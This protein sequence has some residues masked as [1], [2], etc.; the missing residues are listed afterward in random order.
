MRILI[1]LSIITFSIVFNAKAQSAL[2]L[3]ISLNCEKQ[4]LSSVLSQIETHTALK[5]S[6]NSH[7]LATDSLVTIK[8]AG[9]S[10]VEAL[11]QLLGEHFEFRQAGNFI[12]IRYAP[13]VL[14]ML[15]LETVGDRDRYTIKGQIIERLTSLP[16]ANASIFEK[17]LLVSTLSDQQGYFT[18][19]LKNS[20]QPLTLTVTKDNFKSIEMHFL[21]EVMITTGNRNSPD[22]FF[23]GDSGI[24][25]ETWLG[26]MLVTTRQKIQSLNIGGLL[27]EAPYQ[28][29]IVPGLNSHGSL[30]GQ[31]INKLS[32]N[33]IGAYSAGVDG[34]EVGLVFNI[35]K[36]DVKSFQ[37]AGVF[38]LV[39]GDVQ[40][41]QIAGLAN[42]V[43]GKVRGAQFSLGYNHV[44]KAFKGTQVGAI[45]NSVNENF[46]GVQASIGLNSVGKNLEGI[47]AAVFGNL[48]NG[49]ARGV[50]IAGLA[51]LNRA[52]DGLNVATLLNLTSQSL[53]GAQVGILNYAKTMRGV[54]VGLMNISGKNDGYSIG[55]INIAFHGYHKFGFS[56]NETTPYNLTYRGGSRRFYNILAVGKDKSSQEQL[57]TAGLGFGKELRF[58]KLLALNP[59]ISSQYVYQ[60]SWKEINILNKLELGLQLRI[61]SWIA[62]S[63]APTLNIYHTTQHRKIGDFGLLQHKHKD[64]QLNN[65][66]YTGWF[67]W[68]AGLLL[69]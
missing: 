37:F 54:Q 65:P 53:R 66:A 6:F 44:G 26:S 49:L 13:M 63:A 23:G 56:T 43:M 28:V 22:R 5:F 18:L 30:S 20:S 36:S 10:L 48:S 45:Y 7:I 52:T 2:S 64:F 35:D 29:A 39:G 21:S 50:Q 4:K 69:L 9:I 3:K 12:I 38:N 42:Y 60:G 46:K 24:I 17:N 11:T 8:A 47:Q 51:N 19:E 31:I 58:S 1:F 57:Y 67:G 25:E 32:F 55:L 68:S 33:A 16:V 15:V 27:S 40:G 59:E 61:N 62:L 34:A 14:S 41:L